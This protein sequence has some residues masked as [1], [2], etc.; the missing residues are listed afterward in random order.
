MSNPPEAS[1]SGSFGPPPAT[2]TGTLPL[3]PADTQRMY[4]SN[5]VRSRSL[6]L[7]AGRDQSTSIGSFESSTRTA[8]PVVQ[9]E[10]KIRTVYV[11][12]QVD[13]KGSPKEQLYR[14]KRIIASRTGVNKHKPTR[15]PGEFARISFPESSA[16]KGKGIKPEAVPSEWSTNRGT[17]ANEPPTLP[18]V[19]SLPPHDTTNEDIEFLK[20]SFESLRLSGIQEASSLRA[21]MECL[22]EENEVKDQLLRNA[23][24]SLKSRNKDPEPSDSDSES[25][26]SSSSE[27]KG[28]KTENKVE[29]D[30]PPSGDKK[31][32]NTPTGKINSP[33]LL[34]D[35]LEIPEQSPF[36]PLRK[37]DRE[38]EE[39]ISPAF[40]E[41]GTGAAGKIPN[42][43]LPKFNGSPGNLQKWSVEFQRWLRMTNN[44]HQSEIWKRDW[45]I[46]ACTDK[47]RERVKK[48]AQ[49][50]LT[51]S[52]IILKLRELT[53][54]LT[55]SVTVKEELENVNNLKSST[56]SSIEIEDLI[57][58]FDMVI[59][60]LPPG[61]MSTE[62][63]FLKFLSKIHPEQ[64]MVLR[65]DSQWNQYIHDLPHVKVAL[66]K[67]AANEAL[68]SY[69]E[70]QNRKVQGTP[71]P[72][73]GKRN[74][75]KGGN[76]QARVAD[77]NPSANTG[78]CF[79]CDKPG[80]FARECPEPPKGGGK[81]LP[82]GGKPGGK[83]S[84]KPAGYLSAT[85]HCE[86]C[87]RKNHVKAN[88]FW[89][90][91]NPNNRI[92]E[93]EQKAKLRQQTQKETEDKATGQPPPKKAEETETVIVKPDSRKKRKLDKALQNKGEKG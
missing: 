86:K 2:G 46:E 55:N 70:S 93:F 42:V 58:N 10:Q 50:H 31:S 74:P 87:K 40:S 90:P 36:R 8:T 47:T 83:P 65:R 64:L 75:P 71:S 24:S 1:G 78:N 9:E 43:T 81:T 14:K 41:K 52:E 3:T 35:N 61:S 7:A 15:K 68:L 56:P 13:R 51:F 38:V 72:N 79:N 32:G 59:E 25:S 82:K 53:P 17:Q 26:S 45:L 76:E 22:R 39:L 60:E 12:T 34:L 4:N 63:I 18:F 37:G 54:V 5:R 91:D 48:L 29:L 49:N 16:N 73:T 92:A 11:P 44:T 57:L 89:D 30:T 69:F 6:P 23:R 80:H 19:E 27:S 21:E 85:L 88:C 33:S 28:R 20:A 84:G 62:D 77:G 67:V 66:R